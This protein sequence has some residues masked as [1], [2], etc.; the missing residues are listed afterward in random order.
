MRSLSSLASWLPKLLSVTALAM[1][2]SGCLHNPLEVKGN[3]NGSQPANSEEATAYKKAIVR[4][5]KIGGSR[6]VKI[7]GQLRCY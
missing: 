1:T 7:E 4:C 2:L 3:E 5:Y 6:V